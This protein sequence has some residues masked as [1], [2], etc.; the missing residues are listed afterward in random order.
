MR[1]DGCVV[2]LAAIGLDDR[3]RL[4]PCF[5]KAFHGACKAVFAKA[6]VHVHHGDVRQAHAVHVL[7]RLF[8]LSLVAGAHVEHQRIRGLVE[9][10]G[11]RRGRDQGNAVFGQQW[12]DRLGMRCG[13]AH[14]QRDHVVCFDQALS[15][16]TG[17]LGFELVVKRDQ[18]DLFTVDS[19][20]GVDTVQIEIHAHQGL[21]NTGRHGAAHGR[22][23]A[24]QNFRLGYSCAKSRRQRDHDPQNAHPGT[25]IQVH[26]Y[27]CQLGRR[28]QGNAAIKSSD[29]SC[30]STQVS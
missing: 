6:V 19:A 12:Q 8:G 13:P 11:A 15:V 21:T 24:D 4:D 16:F 7:H 29:N 28:Y 9:D 1:H 10:H 22:G 23:L 5:V 26:L 18:F 17:E 25:K 30:N 14:E 3:Q 20:L 2:R 27:S